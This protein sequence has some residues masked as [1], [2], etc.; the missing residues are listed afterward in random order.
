MVKIR[1]TTTLHVHHASFCRRYNP[2]ESTPEEFSNIKQIVWNGT[3]ILNFETVQN[4]F[5][6]DV[7][8]AVA[9]VVA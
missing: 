9:V 6:G 7:F 3:K 1:K 2:L 8:T 4:R 5:P